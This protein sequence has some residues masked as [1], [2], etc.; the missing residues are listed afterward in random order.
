MAFLFPPD[1]SDAL[2]SPRRLALVPVAR[3]LEVLAPKPG[4]RFLDVGCGTGTFFFPLFEKVGGKGIFLAAELQEELLRRFLTRLETYTEHPGYT[5]IEVLRAKPERLPLPDASAD[6]VLLAQVYHELGDRHAYLLEL[7]RVLAP[8]GTLCL[9]DWRT[10]SEEAALD[11]D[12]SPMGPPFEH[13]ISEAQACAEL[14]EA[15]F[16]WMVSHPGFGQN[17]CITTK[18]AGA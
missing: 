17:W 14:Q 5:R 9:L 6:L 10:P 3:L 4:L 11:Q 18:K 1:A 15:G 2:D 12:P 13:R 16:Q 8:G 7:D